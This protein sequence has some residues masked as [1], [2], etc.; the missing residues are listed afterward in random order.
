[1]SSA[2]PEAKDRPILCRLCELYLPGRTDEQYIWQCLSAL[3]AT[4]FVAIVSF[5]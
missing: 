3:V 4:I 2:R 1:M 5:A